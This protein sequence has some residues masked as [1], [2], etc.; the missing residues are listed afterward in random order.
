MNLSPVRLKIALHIRAGI[1]AYR[2][3]NRAL[4]NG[5]TT[6]WMHQYLKELRTKG[7]V[8]WDPA[9]KRTLQLTE[10][11]RTYL[12]NYI[13]LPGGSVGKWEPVKEVKEPIYCTADEYEELQEAR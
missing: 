1:N 10:R 9:Q 6:G 12:A 7:L 13:L 8:T 11:G 2:E 3:L 4:G 5:P